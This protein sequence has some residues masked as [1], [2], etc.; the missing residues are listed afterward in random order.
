VNHP[1]AIPIAICADDFGFSPGVNDAILSLARLGRLSAVSCL[2]TTP[3][4]A[5]VAPELKHLN[6]DLGLHLNFTEAQGAL[7]V[8]APV[9]KLILA[10]YTG[11]LSAARVLT[12]I[13]QQLDAFE[14]ALGQMPDF[15]DGHEHVHQF[16]VI[17]DALLQ[18]L[19]RR[20]PN[21]PVWLRDTTPVQLSAGLPWKQRLKAHLIAGL[22]ATRLRSHAS[23]QGLLLNHAFVGVYDFA[24]PHPPYLDMLRFWLGDARPASLLMVHP[25]TSVS[26]EDAY[27]HDRVIE[28]EVLGSDLFANLLKELGLSVQRLSSILRA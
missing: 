23:R 21:I 18:T 9:G 3:N 5:P 15:V 7:D 16:P 4:F 8:C 17:R 14:S 27:G 19:S 25:A 22:G 1:M 20:Y 12:Q 26:Q 10:A 11:Q 13:N 24:R 28:F 2:S 6:A